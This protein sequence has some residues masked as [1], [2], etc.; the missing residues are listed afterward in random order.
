MSAGT[1]PVGPN[2][3]V[4]G[5]CDRIRAALAGWVP[6]L[7]GMHVPPSVCGPVEV[8][9]LV[10]VVADAAELTVLPG[11]AAAARTEV[12]GAAVR[13]SAAAGRWPGVDVRA[14][15][16]DV[17]AGCRRAAV[18]HGPDGPRRLLT[19]LRGG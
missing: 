4:D 18:A 6:R 2:T 13:E 1:V 7:L 17:R 9:R 5:L 16:A 8:V 15:L 14:E 19:L 3:G 10:A 12:H 11:D